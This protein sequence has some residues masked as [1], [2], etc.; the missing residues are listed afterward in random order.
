MNNNW[1]L[2]TP[3]PRGVCEARFVRYGTAILLPILC[4][5]LVYTRPVL[6]QSPFYIFLGGILFTATFAGVAPSFLA[7]AVSVFLVRLLF[8][9]PYFS[10]Y[11]K[12][13]VQD[14]ERICWFTLIALML[15]SLIAGLRKERNYLRDS[16]ER[17]RIL[18][19]SASDAIIVI[20]EQE[21]I[22]FVNP[23]AERLF[24]ATAEKLLGQNLADLLP[25]EAY[26][27]PLADLKLHLDSR[28][29]A[30]AVQLPCRHTSGRN[31]LVEMTLGSFAKHG[32]NLFTAILR[33]ITHHRNGHGVHQHK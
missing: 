33:E 4:V 14:A 10:L 21:T 18:A 1:K 26:Q 23:V 3:L 2:W 9:Q 7:T 11:H 28:Q 31:I 16:E 29:P 6:M 20:D 12:G 17:Y 32:Q 13:N 8:I 24:G 27:R 30:I 19:E 25:D 15:G 22:R 5:I